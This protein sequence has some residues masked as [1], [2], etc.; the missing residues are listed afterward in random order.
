MATTPFEEK[1]YVQ[2]DAV[3]RAQQALQA[4]QAAKPGDYRS[5]WQGKLDSALGEIQNRPDFSYDVNS[6]ALYQQVAQNYLR[7]GQQAMMDTAG[8]AAALTG[9]YG[10]SYGQTAGQQVYN[11]YLQGLTELV[12]Q[13]RQLALEQYRLEGEDL[14][15]Q[16]QL[17]LDQ[18]N[19]DYDRYRDTLEDYYGALDRL[20]A[21]YD[22]ERSYDYSR[23]ADSRDF[24]YGQHMDQRNHQ[25]RT[26][27]DAVEDSQWLQQLQYQQ[28]RDRIQDEQW[29]KEYE[30]MIRQYNQDYELSLMAKTAASSGSRSSSGGR[31]S[32]S[33][34]KKTAQEEQK[35]E[36]TPIQTFTEYMNARS[37]EG[38]TTQQAAQLITHAANTGI[39]EKKDQLNYMLIYG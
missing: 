3:T 25:Y 19:R 20:Q 4:Q 10:N 26:D 11:Q 30:E 9:G 33:G 24:A 31:S 16:Y 5:Q 18:E 23:Y 17:L 22:Q 27:R 12:P 13:Y 14:L 21:A 15:K 7:Q 32:G 6:D 1:P 37:R 29:Q 2:S 8:Q 36:K 39:I 35:T 34:S 38:M 28:E